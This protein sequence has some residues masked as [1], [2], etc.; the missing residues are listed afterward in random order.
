MA[1]QQTFLAAQWADRF[2]ESYAELPAD[3]QATCDTAAIALIKRESSP[4]LRVKPIHPDKYYYE[5]RLNS[6][7]RI[8][9][10]VDGSTIYFVDVVNHDAI[11]RY[12]RRP[13]QIQGR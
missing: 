13:K 5:A 9:F 8:V 2:K 3:K 1:R 10:R 6:G 12:G 7:D 4:G 11:D